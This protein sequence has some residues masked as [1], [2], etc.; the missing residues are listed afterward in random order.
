MAFRD[1]GTGRLAAWHP[2]KRLGGSLALPEMN[3]LRRE[4]SPQS[5]PSGEGARWSS[6]ARFHA[7]RP[8]RLM[9]GRSPA[10]AR[11]GA[12][13]LCNLASSRVRRYGVRRATYLCNAS[14]T[15]AAAAESGPNFDGSPPGPW[16][17]SG[18]IGHSCEWERPSEAAVGAVGVVG[19]GS[20]IDP[21]T[22]AAIINNTRELGRFR[23]FRIRGFPYQQ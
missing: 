21:S 9:R 15:C 12:S 7:I 3:V 8:V 19:V 6:R 2:P 14:I 17:G 10:L 22:A 18:Q 4:P 13:G 23:K 16:S 11:D 1:S 20:S 5:V